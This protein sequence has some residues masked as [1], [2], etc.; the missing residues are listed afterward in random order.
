M[1]LTLRF[2]L[3]FVEGTD[4]PVEKMYEELEF[5]HNHFCSAKLMIELDYA[6]KKNIEVTIADFLSPIM[7]EIKEKKKAGKAK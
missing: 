1:A 5:I 7:D 6:N 3:E 4:T 2:T